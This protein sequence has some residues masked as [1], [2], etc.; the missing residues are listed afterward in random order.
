MD[1]I[2]GPMKAL[3]KDVRDLTSLNPIMIASYGDQTVPHEFRFLESEDNII[4]STTTPSSAAVAVSDSD[5]EDSI[6]DG[7]TPPVA[8]PRRLLSE[9]ELEF[10][11]AINFTE[12]PT[13]TMEH[14]SSHWSEWSEWS[15]IEP[16]VALDSTIFVFKAGTDS[17]ISSGTVEE[18]DPSRLS[19]DM[20]CALYY[21]WNTVALNE[22]LVTFKEPTD[23]V[24]LTRIKME[25]AR[26]RI[27]K[28]VHD[29]K[30]KAKYLARTASIAQQAIDEIVRR[31]P[32]P[33]ASPEKKK[34]NVRG[35]AKSSPAKSP[36]K[37]PPQSCAGSSENDEDI[38]GSLA[39]LIFN[40]FVHNHPIP[41]SPV[42]KVYGARGAHHSDPVVNA[43]V[44]HMER[45]RDE[46]HAEILAREA[47]LVE[48]QR[49]RRMQEEAERIQR[50]EASVAKQLAK[51]KAAEAEAEAK[52]AAAAEAARIEAKS[53]AAK[54]EQEKAK[55]EARREATKAAELAKQK[56]LAKA[57]EEAV[58]A[59]EA[60]RKAALL[61][62]GPTIKR[63]PQVVA[64]SRPQ[65]ALLAPAKRTVVVAKA[66]CEICMLPFDG[67]H[68]IHM[69]SMCGLPVTQ[70]EC[71]ACLSC[72]L[73]MANGRCLCG[74]D[75]NIAGWK[76]KI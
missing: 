71:T 50:H 28:K 25:Q 17:K 72:M 12:S 9:L 52:R 51:Q 67:A 75:V 8:I 4:A 74:R 45:K 46:E 36:A 26:K 14:G 58:K 53:R 69:Y 29:S 30:M 39:Q 64:P 23:P 62:S 44:A 19:R 22:W 1:L 54:A 38:E 47:R 40:E 11:T 49:E 37:T 70:H 31:M 21:E 13:M 61:S 57:R 48:Q 42:G 66:G 35:V 68:R 55:K 32:A 41:D 65:A 43:M 33:A 27:A 16:R 20:N 7:T 5:E 24:I 15:A 2:D 6:E 63:R 76:R 34:K 56:M 60:L 59:Q 73:K 18:N 3:C 10:S